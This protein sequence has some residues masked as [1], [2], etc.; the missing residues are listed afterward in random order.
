ME[1][2]GIE[3]ELAGGERP[4]H[5]KWGSGEYSLDHNVQVTD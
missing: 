4:G 2:E 1:K 5:I 3:I